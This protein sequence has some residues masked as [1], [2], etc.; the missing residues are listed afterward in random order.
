MQVKVINQR[1]RRGKLVACQ[2]QTCHGNWHESFSKVIFAII[3]LYLTLTSMTFASLLTLLGCQTAKS[4][5]SPSFLLFFL[6][7]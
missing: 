4:F 3:S 7:L 5:V 6:G 2:D 1:R